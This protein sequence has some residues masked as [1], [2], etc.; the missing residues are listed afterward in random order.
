MIS[1]KG[2]TPI[3][4]RLSWA[5]SSP[6]LHHHLPQS[7][8]AGFCHGGRIIIFDR[9]TGRFCCDQPKERRRNHPRPHDL[10]RQQHARRTVLRVHRWHGLAYFTARV[11]HFERWLNAKRRLRRTMKDRLC[12]RRADRAASSGFP[13]SIAKTQLIDSAVTVTLY[14]IRYRVAV[15]VHMDTVAATNS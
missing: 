2:K 14:L 3:R 10:L 1:R 9:V 7:C 4:R 6:K 5:M 15:V 12:M 8:Q 11:P 13:P